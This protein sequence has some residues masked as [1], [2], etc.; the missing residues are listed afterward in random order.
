MREFLKYRD[1]RVRFGLAVNR[2]LPIEFMEL[3][4]TDKDKKVKEIATINYN[5][6]V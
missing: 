4:T 6:R 2:K 1:S 3:L 5:H